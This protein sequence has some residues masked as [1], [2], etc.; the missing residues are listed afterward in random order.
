VQFLGVEV[1][2]KIGDV[3]ARIKVLQDRG[4]I[5]LDDEGC[6]V[7]AAGLSLVPTKHAL[8]IDGRRFW[9]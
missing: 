5:Q 2:W 7:G 1:D 6:I 9:A 8:S 3:I 4:H